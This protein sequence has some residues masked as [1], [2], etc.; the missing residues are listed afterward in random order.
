MYEMVNE[1]YKVLIPIHEASHDYERLSLVHRDLHE[2]FTNIISNVSDLCVLYCSPLLYCIQLQ[3]TLIPSF[4]FI[5]LSRK[6]KECLVHTSVLVSMVLS[7][8]I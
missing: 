7:L 5:H 6:V 1:V 3:Y 8:E 4:N 2:A